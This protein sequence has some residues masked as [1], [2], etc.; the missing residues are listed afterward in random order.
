[1][2]QESDLRRIVV[3]LPSDESEYG[4]AEDVERMRRL[5]EKHQGERSR[6]VA[7]L[8]TRLSASGT[9]TSAAW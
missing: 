8:A 3:D 1:M 6:T 4:T 7:W 5:R 2:P 9:P